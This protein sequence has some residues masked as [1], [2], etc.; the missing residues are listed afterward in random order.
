[1]LDSAY[2]ESGYAAPPLLADFRTVARRVVLAWSHRETAEIRLVHEPRWWSD[3]SAATDG[4]AIYADLVYAG[5]AVVARTPD[6]MGAIVVRKPRLRSPLARCFVQALECELLEQGIGAVAIIPAWPCSVTP[7]LLLQWYRAERRWQR[8][9][10]EETA[11]IYHEIASGCL[12]AL[13]ADDSY[14]WNDGSRYYEADGQ[15]IYA[16]AN[17]VAALAPRRGIVLLSATRYR[18]P[19][20][21]ILRDCLRVELQHSGVPF[22][23]VIPK[24]TGGTAGADSLILAWQERRPRLLK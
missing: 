9:S 11:A 7:D 24:R 15:A 2:L 19:H 4:R 20:S 5:E 21:L 17:C 14:R 18:H 1:M 6:G 10:T 8:R 3:I 16:H 13:L 12:D 23:E 22:V